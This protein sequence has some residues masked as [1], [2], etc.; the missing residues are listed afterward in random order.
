[1]H[2]LRVL[3]LLLLIMAKLACPSCGKIVK[4]EHGTGA[5][6]LSLVSQICFI[7]AKTIG[8]KE[9][10]RVYLE[11]EQQAEQECLEQQQDALLYCWLQ[12]VTVAIVVQIGPHL[13]KS[14]QLWY[15]TVT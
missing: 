14:V 3:A 10:R 7:N 8:E 13:Y 5:T 12:L 9:R 2:W 6:K 11:A 15:S 4:G 1:M